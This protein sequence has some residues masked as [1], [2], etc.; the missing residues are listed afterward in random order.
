M[1]PGLRLSHK[2]K[3]VLPIFTADAGLYVLDRTSLQDWMTGAKTL[4]LDQC[5]SHTQLEEYGYLSHCESESEMQR[6]Y[7]R[8]F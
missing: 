5:L 3:T 2:E 1:R 8:K 4:I 6:Y 7:N